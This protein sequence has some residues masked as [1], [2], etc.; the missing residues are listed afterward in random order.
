M[1]EPSPEDL[2]GQIGIGVVLMI[3]LCRSMGWTSPAGALP[4]LHPRSLHDSI[5]VDV[6]TWCSGT[7]KGDAVAAGARLQAA[8]P[9]EVTDPLIRHAASEAGL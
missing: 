4:Y 1:T 6:I 5:L 9:P 3:G 2:I 7:A 8:F